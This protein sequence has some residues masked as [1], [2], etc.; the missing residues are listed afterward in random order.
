MQAKKQGRR[1][2]ED[3]EQTQLLILKVAHDL[4]C[5]FG[6][7]GV[8]LRNISDKAGISH[9]LIRHHFG[10]KEQIWFS[11]CNMADELIGKYAI[12]I[13]DNLSSDL[14]PTHR[15]Y[16]FVARLLAF[17][18]VYPSSIQLLSD[19]AREESER[20]NHFMEKMGSRQAEIISIVDTENELGLS[21]TE[22]AEIKWQTIIFAQSAATMRPMMNR[23]WTDQ[24]S[25][26]EQYLLLHWSMFNQWISH[27]F[28]IPESD[29]LK[30]KSLNEIVYSIDPYCRECTYHSLN[31]D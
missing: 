30:P 12:K 4:F 19:V 11:I 28:S 26:D 9:S 1:S 5:E 29:T 25:D 7:A 13:V 8:S 10:S 31:R 22:I 27:K 15:V 20:F 2:A 24:T 16:Q 18:L 3:A 21:Q 14:P 23:I 17:H 6:Y